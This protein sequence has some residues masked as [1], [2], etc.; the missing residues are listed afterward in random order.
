ML[1]LKKNALQKSY[2]R[3]YVK[4]YIKIKINLPKNNPKNGKSHLKPVKPYNEDTIYIKLKTFAEQNY[5][6]L[7]VFHF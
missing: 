3:L 6:L 1:E 2:L 7:N 5:I 4:Y